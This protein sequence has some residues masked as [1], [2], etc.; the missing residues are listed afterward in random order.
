MVTMT[1]IDFCHM[2]MGE[3]AGFCGRDGRMWR[4]DRVL[5]HGIWQNPENFQY[6]QGV[7][8][9]PTTVWMV[10]KRATQVAPL[11]GQVWF[12]DQ[13]KVWNHWHDQDGRCEAQFYWYDSIIAKIATRSILE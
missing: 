9:V 6:R 7:C 8:F 3:S 13:Y 1:E 4:N 11:Q 12:I 5:C 2:F 10:V